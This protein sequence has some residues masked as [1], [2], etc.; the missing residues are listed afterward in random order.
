MLGNLVSKLSIAIT[1]NKSD[2]IISNNK[3]NVYLLE[4]LLSERLIKGFNLLNKKVIKVFLKYNLVG[5]C[6]IKAIKQISKPGR[7]YFVKS[8]SED[9]TKNTVYM[10]STSSKGI[11]T[12]KKAKEFNIGGE[13]LCSIYI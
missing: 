9:Y 6:N 10:V 3:F 5:V 13:V 4:S 2:F 1:H 8:I 7:R 11:I 12:L